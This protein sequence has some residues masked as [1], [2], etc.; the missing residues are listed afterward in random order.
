MLSVALRNKYV[1]ACLCVVSSMMLAVGP[2]FAEMKYSW[3]PY[4]RLRHEYWK[5]I[6]DADNDKLDNRNFFRIK[7]SLWGQAYWNEK[8]GI[9]LKLT[10]ENK[11]YAYWGVNA[12]GNKDYH[13][14]LHEL[15]IDN[16]Y[17][18][19]KNVFGCPVDLRLGR[20]DFPSNMYGEGFLISDGTPRD[21]SRTF[22]FNAA[23][24]SW[25]LAEKGTLDFIAIKESKTDDILPVAN[26]QDG[27]QMLNY[28][29]EFAYVLY[30]KTDAIENLHWE[31]FYIYKREAQDR[32]APLP[33][34][35]TIN[36]WG[37]YG[38]YAWQPFTFRGQAAYQSGTLGTNDRSGF[39]GYLYVDRDFKDAPWAPCISFGYTYLSGD[40]RGTSTHEGFDQLFSTY[41]W[42]SELYN[43]SY[44]N[45]T[46]TSYWTNLQMWRL[47][48]TATFT[49]RLKGMA[50]YNYLRANEAQTGVHSSFGTGMERGHLQR[51]KVEYAFNKN[52]SAYI[53]AEYFIPGD[54]YA[55]KADA[56]VFVRTELQLKF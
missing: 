25:R 27:E 19:I 46:G 49:P 40:E 41:T 45:E 23:K 16:L 17:A 30:H 21:G 6:F 48:L 29:D 15:V 2:A 20:Q 32:P 34:K 14:D 12:T 44:Q 28:S 53:L 51:I 5:N 1:V 35:S 55:D 10:N 24:A 13:Y 26:R 11:P 42:M 36:T 52:T 9:F 7:T 38:K 54:F 43:L 39:G 18:D 4:L 22:Y 56:S 31:Q 33:D 50:E 47:A 3:G 37:T 8:A